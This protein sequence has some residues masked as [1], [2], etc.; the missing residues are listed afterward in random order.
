MVTSATN[1]TESAELGKAL[2]NSGNWSV[3]IKK[4]GVGDQTG[5]NCQSW[6][7]A[8]AKSIAYIAKAGEDFYADIERRD[9]ESIRFYE[10]ICWSKDGLVSVDA[11]GDQT[12]IKK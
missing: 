6:E 5:F 7:E 10:Q 12:L 2:A 3:T 11:S 9:S 8:T 1:F 4:Y